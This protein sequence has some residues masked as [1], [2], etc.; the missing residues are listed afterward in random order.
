M[1][2]DSGQV[3]AGFVF[4]AQLWQGA[5]WR[6]TDLYENRE[7]QNTAGATQRSKGP[8]WSDGGP[9]GLCFPTCHLPTLT[10]MEAATQESVVAGKAPGSAVTVTGFC[11]GHH[12]GPAT[13]RS[14]GGGGRAGSGC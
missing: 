4:H 2:R 14:L 5:L 1:R 3:T 11:T 13:C 6:G 9:G 8:R 12:S 10:S 7:E